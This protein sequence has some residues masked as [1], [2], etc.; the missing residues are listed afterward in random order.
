MSD[1]RTFFMFWLQSEIL[2]FERPGTSFPIW[3]T[4]SSENGEREKKG[5]KETLIGYNKHHV[6]MPTLWHGIVDFDLLQWKVAARTRLK[7]R[8][9]IIFKYF[10]SKVTFWYYK[11]RYMYLIP[12]CKQK[13]SGSKRKKK[14]D[15]ATR[16]S[17]LSPPEMMWSWSRSL[18]HRGQNTPKYCQN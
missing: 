13:S 8:P 7:L 12:R 10:D 5:G 14:R 16:M 1:P 11:S 9:N 4:L 17:W 18:L 3:D 2:F 15:D 6:A